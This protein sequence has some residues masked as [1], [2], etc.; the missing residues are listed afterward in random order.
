MRTLSLYL[1]CPGYTGP[2][3]KLPWAPTP[4]EWADDFRSMLKS[5]GYTVDKAIVRQEINPVKN[6]KDIEVI[7]EGSK[8]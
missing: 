6:G 7:V 4:I 5:S 3:S 2:D 1:S 8:R